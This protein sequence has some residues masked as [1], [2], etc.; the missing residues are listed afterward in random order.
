M[1]ESDATESEAR[2]TVRDTDLLRVLVELAGRIV[3]PTERLLQIVG[4]Y[5]AAYNMCTGELTLASL[6]R[7]TGIDKSNLRKAILRW[8]QAGAV[9]RV[10]AE[11]RPLRLYPLP[12][13][14]DQGRS[15]NRR[16][17]LAS[18]SDAI[19]GEADG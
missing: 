14:T 11:G 12:G 1:A 18:A 7:A 8:E 15:K 13:P 6:A 16:G 5:A 19:D 10:G 17:G 3:F 2:Y 4:P 9:F